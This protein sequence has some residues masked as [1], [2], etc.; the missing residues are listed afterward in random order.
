MVRILPDKLVRAPKQR[1][2]KHHKSAEQEHREILKTALQGTRRRKLADI[3]ATIPN[4]GE[5][6]D[7]APQRSDPQR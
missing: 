3:L 1:A 6:G 4:V 2:V 7:F 5:D